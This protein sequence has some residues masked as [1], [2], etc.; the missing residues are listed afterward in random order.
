MAK[1]KIDWDVVLAR[2]PPPSPVLCFLCDTFRDLVE[3]AHKTDE[4]MICI[5]CEM[6]LP[7][8]VRTLTP[9]KGMPYSDFRQLTLA[10]RLLHAIETE[11][12]NAP[13]SR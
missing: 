6:R 9:R 3:I 12:K 8:R 2:K 4:V 7:M 13:R 1:L 11:S 10:H 5:H